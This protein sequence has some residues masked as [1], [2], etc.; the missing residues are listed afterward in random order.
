MSCDTTSRT[1]LELNCDLE[2]DYS[3]EDLD[4]MEMYACADE[5]LGKLGVGSTF[6][7]ISADILGGGC[8]G[9]GEGEGSL[10]TSFGPEPK[11]GQN[12]LDTCFGGADV[13]RYEPSNALPHYVVNDGTQCYL[14]SSPHCGK[15]EQFATSAPWCDACSGGNTCPYE[16]KV[17]TFS[18]ASS[19]PTRLR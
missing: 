13:V 11:A 5:A 3:G 14:H 1:R 19:K 7:M 2:G 16:N 17:C 18:Q 15:A 8:N 10:G 6:Y 12:I 4:I 9:I